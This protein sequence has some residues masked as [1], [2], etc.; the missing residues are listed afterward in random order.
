MKIFFSNRGLDSVSD[1][2]IFF[3]GNI[4]LKSVKMHFFLVIP[5]VSGFKKSTYFFTGF[6]IHFG[7]LTGTLEIVKKTF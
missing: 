5:K 6:R 7:F 1:S 3:C 2:T 4:I